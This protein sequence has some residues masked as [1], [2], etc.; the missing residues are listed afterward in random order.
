[1]DNGARKWANFGA[2]I[3]PHRNGVGKGANYLYYGFL[4]FGLV[5]E[6]VGLGH[7]ASGEIIKTGECVGEGSRRF[8]SDRTQGPTFCRCHGRLLEELR[9]DVFKGETS[10]F[11]P[12]KVRRVVSADV[13]PL[14]SIVGKEPLDWQQVKDADDESEAVDAVDAP[15]GFDSR[16]GECGSDFFVGHK[17]KV[18]LQ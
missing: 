1:V 2:A 18:L 4:D 17:W 5:P 16:A 11:D 14:D 15:Y 6:L 7:W 9:G 8:L 12:A 13:E 3:T 10:G